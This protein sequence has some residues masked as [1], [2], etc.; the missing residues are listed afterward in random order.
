MAEIRSFDAFWAEM[1]PSEHFVQIYEADSPFLD[2]LTGFI[3]GGL[4]ADE[5]AVVI[6]TENHRI[7]LIKR[8]D[9]I[10]VD[11][12]AAQSVDQ[13]ILLD[14][15]DTVA[16]FMINGWPDDQRFAQVIA[17]ILERARGPQRRKI[18]AFGEMVAI[19]W[20]NGHSGATVRLEHLWHD[21]CQQEVFCLFCAYPKIGTTQSS[22][23]SLADVLK[24]HSKILPAA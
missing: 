5:A 24:A 18:R 20:A 6:A 12:E 15:D 8:L 7:G 19:L 10:G 17:E 23:D 3:G 9:E 22:L 4:L 21:I 13:L 2:A 1:T 11:V 14:A 16:K